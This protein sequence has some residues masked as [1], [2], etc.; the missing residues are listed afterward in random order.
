ME[1]QKDEAGEIENDREKEAHFEIINAVYLVFCF[2]LFFE[3]SIT[4]VM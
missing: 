4:Y 2:L 1:R 3:T